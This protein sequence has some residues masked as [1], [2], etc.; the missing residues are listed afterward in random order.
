MYVKGFRLDT[1][2]DISTVAE[3]GYIR[4]DWFEKGCTVIDGV[5]SFTE[6][7]WRTLVAD[8]GSDG[9]APPTW[10]RLACRH[11]MN[12]RKGGHLNISELIEKLRLLPE[13]GGESKSEKKRRPTIERNFRDFRFTSERENEPAA[14]QNGVAI[15]ETE[16]AA[17]VKKNRKTSEAT[18]KFLE[19]VQRVAWNRKFLITRETQS[20][21]LAP[22]QAK[23]GDIVCILFGCSVPVLLRRKGQ[24]P[25]CYHELIGECY[26]YGMMDGEAMDVVACKDTE[27]FTLR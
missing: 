3:Q 18:A 24:F 16:S 1:I 21:G 8:R 5:P 2:G 25:N 17:S 10:F 15:G 11:V 12:E 23:Q 9:K 27:I 7:F 14:Q 22:A 6:A 26:V 19:R 4:S 13:K 20:F